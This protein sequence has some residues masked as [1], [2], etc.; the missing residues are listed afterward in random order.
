M[1]SVV[2]KVALVAGFSPSISVFPCQYHSTNAPNS[3]SSACCSYQKD[4]LSKTG[5]LRKSNALSQVGGHWIEDDFGLSLFR[6]NIDTPEML[7]DVPPQTICM[8]FTPVVLLLALRVRIS[9]TP[10]F[11]S[12]LLFINVLFFYYFINI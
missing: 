8:S 11:L 1:R 7:D 5:N 9:G 4:K 2:D 3:C 6:A 10:H 12:F